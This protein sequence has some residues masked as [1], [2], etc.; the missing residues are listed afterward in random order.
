MSPGLWGLHQNS[1]LMTWRMSGCILPLSSDMAGGWDTVHA[2]GSD[3][4]QRP[5]FIPNFYPFLLW[6]ILSGN[7]PSLSSI[8][9]SDLYFHSWL[10]EDK[11][12]LY[13]WSLPGAAEPWTPLLSHAGVAGMRTV[14]NLYRHRVSVSKTH[15][16][17]LKIPVQNY[18][19]TL[20]PTLEPPNTR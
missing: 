10:C 1:L 18:S 12:S 15:C 2:I 19:Q 6:I 20:A 7:C 17:C 3:I 5:V 9:L 11:V 14:L 16:V 13:S 8:F 4:C